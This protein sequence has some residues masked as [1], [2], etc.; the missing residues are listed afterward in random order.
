MKKITQEQLTRIKGHYSEKYG[1]AADDWTAC[2][3]N[4]NQEMREELVSLL[5]N[6][7]KLIKGQVE[8]VKFESPRQAFFYSLGKFGIISLGIV[9]IIIYALDWH[10]S[11]VEYQN[12]RQVLNEYPNLDKYQNIYKNGT[13]VTKGNTEYLVV[14]P[15]GKEEADFGTVYQYD[16]KNKR[17]L[18]PIR[19][20]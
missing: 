4:E 6:A 2:I 16:D 3:H 13:T 12:I 1:I 10:S 17:V 18:V 7:S 11:R 20:K 5:T 15:L 8:Q 19:T 9:S 14:Y